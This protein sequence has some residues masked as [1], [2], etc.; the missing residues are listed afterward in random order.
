VCQIFVT[1]IRF[2]DIVKP[3]GGA[4]GAMQ[5]RL[6]RTHDGNPRHTGV[7]PF[8]R[9]FLGERFD[10]S[11]RGLE[12]V[13]LFFISIIRV[14]TLKY[15]L[16]LVQGAPQRLCNFQSVCDDDLFQHVNLFVFFFQLQL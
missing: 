9:M 7:K 14:L 5:R 15:L 11:G 1:L 6:S 8:V 3:P 12:T 2:Q 4:F 13:Y 16:V 10:Q